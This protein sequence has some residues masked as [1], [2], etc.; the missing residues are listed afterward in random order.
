[1]E[2]KGALGG[3]DL[4]FKEDF[5][6]EENGHLTLHGVDLVDLCSRYGTPLFVFDED[7][8]VGNFERFRQAFESN[9]PKTI[10]CYS[11][12]TNNNLAICEIMQEKG[13]YA[14]VASELDLYV[15]DEAGFPGD[16]IIF[17]GPHKSE[18]VLR[19]ALEKEVLLINVESLAEMER[20]DKIS[21]EMGI[22]QSVGLRVN[23]FEPPGFCSEINPGNLNDA[24]HCHPHCRF[25][26]AR[27]DVYPVFEQ[28]KDFSNLRLEGIMT[29]PYHGAI[30]VLWPL[31]QEI[32]EKL[33]IEV[34]YLNVGGGFNPGTVRSVRYKDLVLDLV[35]QRIG[36]AS[37][38]DSK[39]NRVPDIEDVAKAMADSIRQRMG[40]LPEPTIVTEPGQFIAGPA[41]ILLL[42]VDHGKTAGGCKWVIVDGGTNLLP[43]ANAFT[44][45][46]V[47]VANKA[48]DQEEEMVNIVGPLLY[49]DDVLSVKVRLPRVDEGDILAILDCG[50]Y[51]LSSSTQFLHP[52]PAA[53]LLNAR[54]EVRMVREKETCEDVL[55]KDRAASS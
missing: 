13:A 28:S 53:I 18:G 14:E 50:A 37:V 3:G 2:Q 22:E 54:S 41:G 34:K 12:K 42:R 24:I 29:H 38:L 26:F 5:D 20:L 16:H 33:G 1:M 30:D 48:G 7:R 17:D 35:R 45:R 51:S 21:A 25:G 44:R 46:Q 10:V 15:A 27:D 40:D 9:Y 23:P 4:L 11:I 19:K 43:V 47:V 6:V 39:E 55:R 52:R 32:H 8:L 49:S 36:L 31:V